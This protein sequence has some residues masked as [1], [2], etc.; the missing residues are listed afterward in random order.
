MRVNEC[1]SCDLFPWSDG[2]HENY[3][4]PGI[5][6]DPQEVSMG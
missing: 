5:D 2:H 4:L 6:L 1:V 3:I